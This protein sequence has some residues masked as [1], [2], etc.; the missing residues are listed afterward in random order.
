MLIKNFYRYTMFT[1]QITMCNTGLGWRENLFSVLQ[2]EI[3]YLGKR[4]NINQNHIVDGVTSIFKYIYMVIGL[5]W[6]TQYLTTNQIMR[7]VIINKRISV[8]AYQW[9]CHI[10]NELSVWTT[11]KGVT[12]KRCYVYLD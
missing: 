1:W 11:E 10:C 6:S 12:G 8:V 3:E 9:G 7:S 4:Q 5:H 2:H